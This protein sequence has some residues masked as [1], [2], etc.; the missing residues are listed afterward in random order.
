MCLELQKSMKE[1]RELKQKLY[2]LKQKKSESAATALNAL[3][4]SD[5]AILTMNLFKK[6]HDEFEKVSFLCF[7]KFWSE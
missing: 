4:A 2:A 5:A 7:L 1:L 3:R 6:Y